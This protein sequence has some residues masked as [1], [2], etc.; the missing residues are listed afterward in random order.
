[1]FT[2]AAFRESFPEFADIVKYPNATIT[3]WSTLAIAQVNPN[4][5]CTQTDLGVMLYTAHEITLAAQSQAAGV[6]GG[7]PG[8]QGVI[9]TKTVGSVTVGYDTEQTK[10]RDGG[11]WNQ[12]TYGRQFLRLARIFGAGCVQL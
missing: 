3:V 6:I 8:S 11:Y 12:T 10:E 4:L 7:T 1:M 9:N 2:I 5:W